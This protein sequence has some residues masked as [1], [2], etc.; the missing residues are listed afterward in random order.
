VKVSHLLGGYFEEA[1]QRRP[2]YESNFTNSLPIVPRRSEWKSEEEGLLRKFE[3][4]ERSSLKDFVLATLDLEDDMLHRVKVT[5]EDDSVSVFYSS[6]STLQG[7][8]RD[9]EFTG[10]LDEVYSQVNT[11]RG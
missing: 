3:F 9:K 2:L 1:P 5:I 11:R 8:Q 4:R 10:Y 6:T 7:R